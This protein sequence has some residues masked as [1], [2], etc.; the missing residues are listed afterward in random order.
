M[1]RKEPNPYPPKNVDRPPPP[2]SPPPK[3]V[4]SEDIQISS[5]KV[6]FIIKKIIRRQ[7]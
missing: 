7:P 1:S 6:K 4:L 2:P 5:K 3:R